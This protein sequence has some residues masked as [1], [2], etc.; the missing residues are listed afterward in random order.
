[1]K[2]F[3]DKVVMVTGG[4]RGIGANTV[5]RFTQEGAKVYFTDILTAEGE[6][7]A[8]EYKRQAVF[9]KQDVTKEEDWKDV[10]ETIDKA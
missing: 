6:Q 10:I 7:V 3:E 2:R 5:K 4:T 9:L 1:M 8:D